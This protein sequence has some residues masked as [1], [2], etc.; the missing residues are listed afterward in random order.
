MLSL[1]LEGLLSLPAFCGSWL[2]REMDFL[3]VRI[4]RR[5]EMSPSRQQALGMGAALDGM[6]ASCWSPPSPST[7][8]GH[9]QHRVLEEYRS[10]RCFQTEGEFPSF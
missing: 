3:D 4:G 2:S 7:M 8:L 10:H 5:A 1:G 9:C 6:M